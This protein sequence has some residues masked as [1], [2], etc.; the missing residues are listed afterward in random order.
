MHPEIGIGGVVTHAPLQ[1]AAATLHL[2]HPVYVGTH[3]AQVMAT[4]F[5]VDAKGSDQSS[6]EIAIAVKYSQDL[7]DQRT[8]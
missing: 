1:R 3:S 4:D 2:R 6:V 8:R 5:C 7:L